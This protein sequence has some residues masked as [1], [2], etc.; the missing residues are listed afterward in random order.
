MTFTIPVFT[1]MIFGGRGGAFLW[2][3]R[4]EPEL[5]APA[6]MLVTAALVSGCSATSVLLH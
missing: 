5:R 4:K 2:R 3:S 6:V 1:A